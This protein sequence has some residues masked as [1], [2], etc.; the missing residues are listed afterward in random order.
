MN[1]VTEENKEKYNEFLENH[2]RCNFQQSL[3]WGK[4]KENWKNEVVLALDDNGEIV[5]SIS[6]LI[7]K[8]PIFGNMIYSPRGPVCDV[9]DEKVLKELTDGIKELGKK[10]KAFVLKIEPD[11]KSSD[12]EFRKIVEELKYKIKD[13][14]KNFSEEIQPRYVFR[15]GIK[16]KTEDEIFGNFHQKTRYNIRLAGK[17]GV[18]VKEGTREDLKD[19]HKI[20]VVTRKKR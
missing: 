4:V 17:K 15:L 2:E 10:Y 16:D 14:A 3:M 9:H 6:V 20:M 5:G 12:K 19:F 13:D 11:V 7:R 8:I 18:V 1:L